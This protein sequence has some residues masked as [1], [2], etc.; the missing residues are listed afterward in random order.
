MKKKYKFSIATPY[1]N[2][3]WEEEVEVEFADDAT[4]EEIEN[5]VTE[6]YTEWLLEKNK[7]GWREI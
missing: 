6:T 3:I 5:S 7:G 2:S 4:E 1:I